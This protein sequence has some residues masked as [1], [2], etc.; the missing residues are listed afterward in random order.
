MREGAL[1]KNATRAVM[2]IF[3]IA[4]SLI[5]VFPL[6]WS[7]ISAF[8]NTQQ[9]LGGWLLP[10]THLLE[11]LQ[12]LFEQHNVAR[13]LKNSFATTLLQTF[14]ALAVS[15]IA[16][17]GFEIYHDKAKDTV[18]AILMLAMMVPFVAVLVPLFQMFTKAKLINSWTGFILPSI[19]TPFLIMYFR[20]SARSF[21][22]DTLEAA[23][24]DG[25]NHY[26]T[27][28]SIYLPI[29]K[30]ILAVIAL[31]T[32]VGVW[33]SWYH[34][35]I[36]ITNR[37]WQPLQLCLRRILVE[38]TEQLANA[39]MDDAE[40]LRMAQE[41]QISNNQL[42]YTIIIVS[43]LPMLVAYPFFQKYFVKGVML[44]SLKE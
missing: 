12:H 33:N 16:G 9:I 36:Y 30:P 6:Y 13:A 39:T 20:N 35:S 44:G 27:L 23:R 31:Y 18:M 17:Y 19:A 25:A 3:L 8:N 11:N 24:I 38:Q 15:S 7:F 43:S 4:V 40:T 21:P 10:S 42:K 41:Q 37:E 14:A 29:S 26:R 34:A 22:R 5:S 28:W 2:Y 32:V 1:R